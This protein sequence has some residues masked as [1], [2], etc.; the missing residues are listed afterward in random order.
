VTLQLDDQ[1][2]GTSLSAT[3]LST[4]P[5]E[6]CGVLRFISLLGRSI[7]FGVHN[8][9]PYVAIV[10]WAEANIH[11]QAH[12]GRAALKLKLSYPK[13]IIRLYSEPVSGFIGSLF[14]RKLIQNEQR[15]IRLLP[16]ERIFVAS[17][18]KLV[19]YSSSVIQATTNIPPIGIPHWLWQ[20]L[21]I[22]W[23][24]DMALGYPQNI[25]QL[26]RCRDTNTLRLVFNT[27]RAVYGFIVSCDSDISLKPKIIKLM[28]LKYRFGRAYSLLSLGYNSAIGSSDGAAS[29]I[30]MLY[31]SWPDDC[32]CSLGPSNSLI[33]KFGKRE[34]IEESPA[35]DEGSGRVVAESSGDNILVYDFSELK[36]V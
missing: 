6:N 13:K 36:S 3:H 5:R 8:F 7:A 15:W 26:Y 12:R 18:F 19:L 21:T 35:F 20:S 9:H 28:D 34:W 10:D 27:D 2:H 11:S 17:T 29:R 33:V 14:I 25:S 1:N 4:F 31:Y 22:I 16:G 24:Y 32:G 30:R 23:E